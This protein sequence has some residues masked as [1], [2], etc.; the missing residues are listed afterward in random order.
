MLWDQSSGLIGGKSC[1]PPGVSDSRESNALRP[2]S[3]PFLWLSRMH[4][5]GGP[6]TLNRM[7]DRSDLM[8]DKAVG[9]GVTE[10]SGTAKLTERQGVP[11]GR[12]TEECPLS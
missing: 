4:G 11:V 7:T 9:V 12:E 6:Q 3:L 10:V 5:S 2:C 1:G 8:S